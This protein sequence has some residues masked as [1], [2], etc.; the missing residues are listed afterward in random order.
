MLRIDEQLPIEEL[1]SMNEIHKEEIELVTKL[2]T[3]AK[4]SDTELVLELLNELIKHT[5]EHFS[6]EE[7]LLLDAEYP[8]YHSHKHEHMMQLLDLSSIL[9]FYEMTKDTNS[10]FTYLEDTLTP[11]VK[12]HV[13]N[14]DIPASE[15]LTQ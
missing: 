12:A 13:E 1:S 15:F 2:H 6:S 14:W 11:W 4:E 5:K 3:A 9:S 10:V 7:K 8:D